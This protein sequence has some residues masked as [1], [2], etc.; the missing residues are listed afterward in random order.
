ML[1]DLI[2]LMLASM[3]AIVIWFIGLLLIL[4]LLRFLARF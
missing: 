3:G 4:A 2:V 1:L